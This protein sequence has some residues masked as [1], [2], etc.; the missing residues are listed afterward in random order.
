MA[1][2]KV[3]YPNKVA[4]NIWSSNNANELKAVVNNNADELT[5][6]V[7]RIAGILRSISANAQSAEDLNSALATVN[8]R[9]AELEL[10]NAWQTEDGQDVMARIEGDGVFCVTDPD[11]N[12]GMK[13]DNAGLDAAQLS[14]HFQALIRAIPRL[15][16]LIGSVAGTA[17]DASLGMRDHAE[18]LGLKHKT[19]N[20]SET[21]EQGFTL[22]DENGNVAFCVDGNGLDVALLSA[23]LQGLIRAIPG[24]GGSGG[25]VSLLEGNLREVAEDGF[26][27]VDEA[28]H[29]G[30][31]NTAAGSAGFGGGS[32][33]E[34][35]KQIDY[36]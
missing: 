15:G 10:L 22:T 12:I 20:L 6:L 28:G 14:A 29:I 27:L 19:A 11:G 23:H 30:A 17:Y 9:L 1:V 13:Y 18:I 36:A 3:Q 7:N 31:Y 8:R 33:Y 32:S 25:G 24:I 16:L 26:F 4:G 2:Q 21:D 35:V 34:V 5:A